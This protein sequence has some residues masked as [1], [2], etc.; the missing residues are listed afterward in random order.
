MSAKTRT[1]FK[2]PFLKLTRLRLKHIET[3][4]NKV[5]ELEGF[6]CQGC[7]DVEGSAS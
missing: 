3:L 2:N 1:N 7:L 5:L 4:D 6:V